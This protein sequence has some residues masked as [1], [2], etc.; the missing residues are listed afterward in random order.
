MV[1]NNLLVWLKL[2]T[3]GLAGP[4]DTDLSQLGEDVYP[5]LEVVAILTDLDLNEV[6]KY[7]SAIFADDSEIALSSD[8]AMRLHHNSGLLAESQES[9]TLVP[10]A[11]DSILELLLSNGAN[12][13]GMRDNQFAILAGHNVSSHE[14]AFMRSKMPR[15]AKFLHHMPLDM[16]TF[17]LGMNIWA[18][19]VQNEFFDE[20]ADYCHYDDGV[21]SKVTRNILHAK[22]IKGRLFGD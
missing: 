2:E 14:M 11:E 22:K 15:L 5:I 20:G 10:D 6:A 18:D 1:H 13:V 12:P 16:A 19:N 3:G 4:L 8:Y 9:G 21:Y 17:T 7:R